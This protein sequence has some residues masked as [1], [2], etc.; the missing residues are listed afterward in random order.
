MSEEVDKHV[1]RKYELIQ[2]LGKGAY[3][4]V[5]KATARKNNQVCAVKKC[6]DAFQNSTDAQRTFR[7][8]MY[9]Q[10]LH[11]H[12]N[13]IQ[14]FNV[15][16]ADNDRDIYIVTDFMESD[17][18]AVI[19]AKILEDV[20]KQ[21][22]IYQVLKALKYMHSGELIHRDI[23]PS[24]ILLNADCSI[25]LCD[26]GLARSVAPTVISNQDSSN[27]V[28]TDYVATRWYRAPEILFGSP[29]YTKG[30]DVWAVGCILAEMIVGK[31]LFPGTSTLDQ[32]ERVLEIT[33]C[34]SAADIKAIES[35]YAQT[36]L[37]S[38][39]GTDSSERRGSIHEFFPTASPDAIDFLKQC[40]QFNPAKRP[41]ISQL[42]NHKYV[43]KFHDPAHE[44]EY[45][46]GIIRIPLDDN[47]KLSVS[48]YRTRLYDAIVQKKRENRLLITKTSNTLFRP[49]PPTSTPPTRAVLP[50]TPPAQ[51]P[52]EKSAPSLI[53]SVASKPRYSTGGASPTTK[54][55]NR[56]ITTDPPRRQISPPSSLVRRQTVESTNGVSNGGYYNSSASAHALAIAAATSA[57]TTKPSIGPRPSSSKTSVYGTS[58]GSRD[59]PYAQRRSLTSQPQTGAPKRYSVTGAAPVSH[60]SKENKPSSIA[61]FFGSLFRRAS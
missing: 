28:M 35:P 34:P 19:K 32:L 52:P 43:E 60:P 17:L 39:R 4:I 21:F 10:A 41:T 26:F 9:L 55:L 44:I 51:P 59:S 33:G 15:L 58:L 61:A 46:N 36:M 31:P 57:A 16:K 42:L 45:P 23:K 50:P 37:D 30:V 47:I 18:H 29:S 11:G 49:P 1:L 22:I 53:T 6:F 14:I 27:P 2:R 3:G 54:S 20:H 7:E 38:I 25:K 56:S 5:W 24:N 40:F 48:D 12:E 13:I 8:I